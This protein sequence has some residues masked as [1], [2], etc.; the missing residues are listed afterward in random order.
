MVKKLLNYPECDVNCTDVEGRTI[1]SRATEKLSQRTIVQFE[2]ILKEKK[3]N[4]NMSDNKDRS[5]L[6]FICALS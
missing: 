5:P 3:A 1:I 4:P 6:H 2:F